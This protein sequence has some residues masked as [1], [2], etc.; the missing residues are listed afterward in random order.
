MRADTHKHT[1]TQP[2][3]PQ[4]LGSSGSHFYNATSQ[5]FTL[6]H[7]WH[8]GQTMPLHQPASHPC[9]GRAL[10]WWDNNS[11]TI[12]TATTH[13]STSGIYHKADQEAKEKAPEMDELVSRHSN[14]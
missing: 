9:R 13:S 8:R 12:V 1:H 6:Y 10:S 5:P 11:Q 2:N 14:K 4:E 3:L 7:R